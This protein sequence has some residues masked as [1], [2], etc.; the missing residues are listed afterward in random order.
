MITDPHEAGVIVG[1][2]V[3]VA[4]LPL[5]AVI[6]PDDRVVRPV[7]Y[8][9]IVYDVG[10]EFANGR[11]TRTSL[12]PAVVHR[13]L[14]IIRD[15]LHCTVIRSCGRGPVRLRETADYALRHGLAVLFSPFLVD[16]VLEKTL[17]YLAECSATPMT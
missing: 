15:D 3:Q 6:R 12:D 10:T 13:E 16:V 9:G 11:S 17:R 14:E 8:R 4:A 2:N 5:Q 1:P 7:R